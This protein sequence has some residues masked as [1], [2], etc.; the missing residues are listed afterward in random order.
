MSRQRQ[1]GF[2]ITEL[3]ISIT[4]AG[5]LI[6]I[7]FSATFYYYVNAMQAQT[8][9]DLALESQSILAQLTEDI[10]LSDAISS[11]NAISDPNSPLGGWTTSD[12]SNIIIIENPA[13]DSSRNIIYNSSTG[14]P[15]RNEFIYFQNS[16][17]MYKRV[18]A[19]A[20][21]SGNTAQTTC[22]QNLASPT[23]PPDR[24]FSSNASNLSF[25]FYD[26][27]D[28]TTSNAT[29]ARSVNLQVDMAKK[30]FGKNIVLSN[31]TRVT[32]RNL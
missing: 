32:L 27:S 23:C 3:V 15:Y 13:V 30:V 4:V 11:T 12:P 20:A 1:D 5:V 6:F 31:T 26:S 19:N 25:T 29:Q 22:P 18:L 7:L 2:T 14:Y 8:A 24:L 9:T 21:A 16:S 28:N 10:R 17:K